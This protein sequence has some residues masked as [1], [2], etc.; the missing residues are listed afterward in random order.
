MKAAKG[1]KVKVHYRGTLEDGE[2]FDSSEGGSPLE[3]QIGGGQVIDGFEHH[4]LGLGAWESKTFTLPPE[5]AYGEREMSVLPLI[6]GKR[7]VV[8][9][10]RPSGIGVPFPPAR[11]RRDLGCRPPRQNGSGKGRE[12][13][14]WGPP[15][16]GWRTHLEFVSGGGGRGFR[17]RSKGG[18]P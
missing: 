15:S 18:R 16:F 8:A 6:T 14:S 3:F 10:E 2:E 5:E 1:S 13:A 4:V 12:L 11:G 17:R 9:V 7:S